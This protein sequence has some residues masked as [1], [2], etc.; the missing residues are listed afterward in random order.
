MKIIILF[1][2]FFLHSIAWSQTLTDEDLKSRKIADSLI[3][4]HLQKEI[5]DKKHVLLLVD[6]EKMV[7]VIKN[8]DSFKE[9]YLNKNTGIINE[10]ILLPSDPIINKMFDKSIYKKGFTTFDSEFFK[11]GYEISS[12]SI[13][14]FVFKDEVGRRY[15]EAKLSVFIKPN[16]VD[17]DVYA[18]FVNRLMFYSNR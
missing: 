11:F 16:P 14:Y 6:N 18:Y 17:T 15:G 8:S 13:T 1:I 2:C 3:N 10:T 9:F 4:D 7:I 5:K 12:G